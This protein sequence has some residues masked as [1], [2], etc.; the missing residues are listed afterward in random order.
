M[1]KLILIH[2]SDLHGAVNSIPRIATFVDQ[3]RHDNPDASVIHI[4]TGD[5]Q[6]KVD[7]LSERTDGAALYRL[8]GAA[9]CQAS[10]VSNKC[11]KSYGMDILQTWNEAGKFPILCCNLS[12]PDGEIIPG[13]Q[14]QTILDAG[15]FKLGVVGATDPD[16]K[17]VEKFGLTVRPLIASIRDAIAGVRAGGADAV[18]LASHLG[19]YDDQD[20]AD[21]LPDLPLILGGHSHVFSLHGFERGNTLIS[22][23][24]AF[25]SH[26]ARVDLTGD[27]AE[28]HIE[29]YEVIDLRRNV[30]PKQEIVALIEGYG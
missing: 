21:S 28:L 29:R 6:D 18:I 24:G 9:G 14:P 30:Q 3:I 25:G 17:Y 1:P 7:P 11:M 12:M 4:D 16:A 27:G 23:I 10:V 2:S 20:V 19:I 22:H 15:G 5:A 26:I 13:T 8:M